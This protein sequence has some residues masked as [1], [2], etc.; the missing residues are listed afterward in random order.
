MRRPP[1]VTDPVDLTSVGVKIGS[2]GGASAFSVLA[3]G[4]AGFAGVSA[5]VGAV[6]SSAAIRII[7]AAMLQRRRGQASLIG[8]PP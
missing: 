3:A 2:A 8:C 7:M 6:A 4:A 1:I 5:A